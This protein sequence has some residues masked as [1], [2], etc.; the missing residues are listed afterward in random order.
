MRN[1]SF[2][3]TC[4][5]MQQVSD[6]PVQGYSFLLLSFVGHTI[7][8]IMWKKVVECIRTL[9]SLN[10]QNVFFCILRKYFCFV[11][12]LPSH[13]RIFPMWGVGQHAL[14]VLLEIYWR[15]VHTKN[16]DKIYENT[17]YVTRNLKQYTF[18]PTRIYLIGMIF[19]RVWKWC[20]SDSNWFF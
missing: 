8:C 9:K 14:C 5:Y 15:Y 2:Y 16:T 10:K 1:F 17:G 6:F 20:D 12:F 13:L 11:I 3:S 18:L 7:N 19:L 4:T